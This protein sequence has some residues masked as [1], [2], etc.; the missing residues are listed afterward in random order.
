MR[1]GAG[2]LARRR[3]LLAAAG[4]A[5]PAPA[6]AARPQGVELLVGAPPGTRTDLWA[7]SIAPFL[8]RAWPRQHVVVRN[9]P[10]RAGLIALAEVAAMPAERKAIATVTVPLS[11]AR[12]VEIAEPAPLGGLA[13]LA[14]LVEEPVVL[15]TAPDGPPS[16]E[17]LRAHEGG[18]LG[19]PPAGGAAHLAAMRLQGR[20]DL[21]RLAFPSA[22]AARQAA[23]AGHIV[24]AL[25]TLPEAIG[26]LREG[27]LL[28]LGIAAA[29]R[30]AALPDLPTFR[31]Q[32]LDL[33]SATRRG[34]ITGAGA[35][36]PWRQRLAAGIEAVAADPDFA[37]QTTEQ[38][39]AARFLGPEAWAALLGRAEAELRARWRD[40]PWLPRRS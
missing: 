29:R 27:R 28:G 34:F 14:A 15:V 40:E 33:V 7:R 1:R 16:L 18:T 23:A 32:G 8:E 36:E 6:L 17:E 13:P 4:L 21:A 9:L 24:A 12:A 26:Q 5:L 25:L 11:L 37:A 2:P 20:L 38:G 19:T 10:G 39:Q 35:A 22:A 31:E 30:S 3:L